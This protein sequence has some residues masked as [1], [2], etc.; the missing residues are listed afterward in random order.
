MVQ[1]K[2]ENQMFHRNDN[3]WQTATEPIQVERRR[4]GPR[5][6]PQWRAPPD[7]HHGQRHHPGHAIDIGSR[8][9]GR[10]PTATGPGKAPHEHRQSNGV[11]PTASSSESHQDLPVK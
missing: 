3:G 6:A 11:A 7:Q 9:A 1:K 2:T 4:S 10:V 8:T 5:T